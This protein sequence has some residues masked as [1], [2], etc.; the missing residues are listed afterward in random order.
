MRVALL[1]GPPRAAAFL[2]LPQHLSVTPS[3][4]RPR[5]P[6]HYPDPAA[7]KD[8]DYLDTERRYPKSRGHRFDCG[9]P[10][11]AASS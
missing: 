10:R 4:M 5:L 9:G 6:G 2:A 1:L 11:T 7:P 3:H 8:L